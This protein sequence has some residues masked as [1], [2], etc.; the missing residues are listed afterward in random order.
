MEREP[1]FLPLPTIAIRLQPA[2]PVVHIAQAAGMLVDKRHGDG[3]LVVMGLGC[4]DA[5]E[6]LGRVH[7][8]LPFALSCVSAGDFGRSASRAALRSS[9]PL[10]RSGSAAGSS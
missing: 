3:I 9:M 2:A 8:A 6:P 5:G 1:L 10:A 4:P 7:A